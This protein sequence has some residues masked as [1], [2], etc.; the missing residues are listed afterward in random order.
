MNNNN[1]SFSILNHIAYQLSKNDDKKVLFPL[2]GNHKKSPSSFELKNFIGR[3]KD[4]SVSALSTKNSSAKDNFSIIFDK[5]SKQSMNK[6]DMDIEDFANA[7][8]SEL[9]VESTAGEKKQEKPQK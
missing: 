6:E 9:E 8:L 3:S 4:E 7:L 5:Q 1:S 2:E